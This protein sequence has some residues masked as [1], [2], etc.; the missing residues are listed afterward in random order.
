M[1]RFISYFEPEMKEQ[2]SH[3]K[4]L[5]KDKEIFYSV[6]VSAIFFIGNYAIDCFQN[7]MDYFVL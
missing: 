1:I 4:V 6:I 5:A 3:Q 7:G 2:E